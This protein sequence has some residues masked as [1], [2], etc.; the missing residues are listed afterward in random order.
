MRNRAFT[1]GQSLKTNRAVAY[2]LFLIDL[3]TRVA[4]HPFTA[5]K[6]CATARTARYAEKS[7][8]FSSIHKKTKGRLWHTVFLLYGFSPSFILLFS[9]SCPSNRRYGY[10]RSRA[11]YPLR[12]SLYVRT[13]TYRL[14]R[15]RPKRARSS[16]PRSW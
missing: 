5:S 3:P 9:G 13:D 10:R 16:H 12:N 7:K 1:F 14:L 15:C 2:F 8:Q 4:Q 6:K 11:C